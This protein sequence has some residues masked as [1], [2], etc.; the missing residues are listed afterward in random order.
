DRSSSKPARN[1]LIS[2]RCR[3]RTE[4]PQ[5]LPGV[6]SLVLQGWEETPE[7]V[8]ARLPGTPARQRAR[9]IF[10][11]LSCFMDRPQRPAGIPRLADY[12]LSCL[13]LAPS[14]S[15]KFLFVTLKQSIGTRLR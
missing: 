2:M 10:S 13:H 7:F 15:E 11:C 1:S 9:Q 3:R 12:W 4:L 8:P 6:P 5:L 14:G